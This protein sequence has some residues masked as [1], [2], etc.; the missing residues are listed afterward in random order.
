MK[1]KSVRIYS[2]EMSTIKLVDR[3]LLS[4]C[5]FK[6]YKYSSGDLAK[7]HL[8]E[9]KRAGD[10]LRNLRIWIDDKAARSIESIHSDARYWKRNDECDMV[11]IDYLQLSE[12]SDE[13]ARLNLNERTSRIS[14]KAKAMAKDLGI[15][16]LLISQLNRDIERRS[17][18]KMPML[19]DLRDSG[20][21]E[22]DADVVLFIYRPRIYGDGECELVKNNYKLND[23]DDMGFYIVAKNRNGPTGYVLF[24]HNESLTNLKDYEKSVNQE[25]NLPF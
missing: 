8:E 16:V 20:A 23:C 14:R 9:I 25:E 3:I 21:I 6:H 18:L 11:I 17:G 5:G 19:S 22:Q 2:L 13:H 7:E 24:R 10:G 4:E 12:V 1:G 15:P